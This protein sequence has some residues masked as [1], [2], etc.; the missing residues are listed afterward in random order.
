MNTP[1]GG[2]YREYEH[3]HVILFFAAIC[4]ELNVHPETTQQDEEND[5]ENPDEDLDRWKNNHQRF[6]E[7]IS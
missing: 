5:G 4:A 7:C 6:S 2:G 1:V 3:Y